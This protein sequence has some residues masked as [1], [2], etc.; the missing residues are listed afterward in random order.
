LDQARLLAVGFHTLIE[1]LVRADIP[2]VFLD[3]PRLAEDGAYLF[4]RLR[5]WLSPNIPEQQGLV[6]HQRTADPKKIR[7]RHESQ[8][9]R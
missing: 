7:V 2:I 5:P 9:R 8:K 4:S 3:F 1:N 6:A